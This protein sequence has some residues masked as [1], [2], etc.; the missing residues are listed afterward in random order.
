MR[1]VAPHSL[2]LS[3]IVEES[4]AEA[5]RAHSNQFVQFDAPIA[6]PDDS[7]QFVLLRCNLIL[8]LR[9]ETESC[10]PKR[11]I[12]EEKKSRKKKQKQQQLV[13]F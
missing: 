13:P 1:C 8:L 6:L 3:A 11:G 10:L 7:G 2:S 12:I 5:A 4:A 9:C